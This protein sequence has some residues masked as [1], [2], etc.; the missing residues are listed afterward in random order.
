[1]ALS[2]REQQMLKEIEQALIGEDPRFARQANAAGNQGGFAFT[3]Q[4]F[5]LIL[6]G[7]CGLVGGIALA[8]VSLWFVVLSVIGFLVMFAGGML[9]FRGAGA[10]ASARRGGVGGGATKGRASVSLSKK[11]RATKRNSAGFGDKME[12]RFKRRFER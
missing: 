4:A 8:Q 12:D 9:S 2:E 11:S 3:M 6:L 1:M 5:A 10:G 7:L